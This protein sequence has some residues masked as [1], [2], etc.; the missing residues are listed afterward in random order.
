[1]PG[2]ALHPSN[3]PDIPT[4]IVPANLTWPHKFPLKKLKKCT[5]PDT[6]TAT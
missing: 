1:M 6:M 2:H 4:G 3:L 5:G